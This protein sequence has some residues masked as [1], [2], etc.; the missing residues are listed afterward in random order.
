MNKSY[1]NI[2]ITPEELASLETTD[3]TTVS[4]ASV[5]ESTEAQPTETEESSE[6]V[7]DTE[8][9]PQGIEIDGEVY[10]QDTIVE[11]M[12]DSQ[13]KTEWSKSNTQK[14]QDV[15][16]WNKLVEKINGDDEFR[17]HIKDYFFDDDSEAD[18]L[19]LNGKFP[20]LEVE[21]QG[22]TPNELEQR[23]EALEEI[24]SERLLDNRVETL[25]SQLTALEEANPSI[26]NEEGVKD[27]LQ[28]TENNAERFT[29]EGMP[30][31]ELAFKE[32]SYDAM[33]DQLAHF[34]KLAENKSR[35]DGKVIGTSEVGA[36]E[37]KTPKKYTSFKEVSME[38]PD[39]AKYFNE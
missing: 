31:L 5:D 21:P 30:S 37:S 25:D 6:E 34:K 8:S 12:K 33:Q 1:N 38:D 11:W 26:L 35:N 4:E 20:D 32:W 18:K 7:N 27:F 23:L 13:N 39:I 9:E 14:A 22:E 19:G 3:E 24:E 15:A 28:F 16:K 2:E 17:E 36:K 29:V 10:D